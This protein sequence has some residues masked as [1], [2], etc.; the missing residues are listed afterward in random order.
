MKEEG[1]IFLMA[2]KGAYIVHFSSCEIK[3]HLHVLPAPHFQLGHTNWQ[4]HTG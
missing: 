1:E 3:S 2:K 4:D